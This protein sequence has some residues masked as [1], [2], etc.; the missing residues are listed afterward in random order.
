MLFRSA[1]LAGKLTA[2]QAEGVQA[3][4]AAQ[5]DAQLDAARDLLRGRRGDE[6]RRLADGVAHCLA[7]VEAG[8]SREDAYVVVQRNTLQAWETGEHLRDLVLADP[9]AQGLDAAVIERAF[10]LDDVLAR[11]EV[12]FGRLG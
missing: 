4:I 9:D 10:S 1:F 2:E 12:P 5:N 8:L 11:A 3:L 6:Y 7:L